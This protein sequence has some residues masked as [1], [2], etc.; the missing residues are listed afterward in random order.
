MAA[1]KGNKYGQR[2]SLKEAEKIFIETLE[3]VR[4]NSEDCLCMQDAVI[5]SGI[6]SRT[7]YYLVEKYEVLQ[8]IKKDINE[9]L[10]SRINKNALKSK[11]NVAASIWR[12]KQL[13]EKD[14]SEQILKTPDLKNITPFSFYE[15]DK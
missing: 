13:G 14:K 5:H 6:P 1:P 8:H 9:L 7:F 12:M 3:F 10:I 2:Y 4:E 15:T 11:Y